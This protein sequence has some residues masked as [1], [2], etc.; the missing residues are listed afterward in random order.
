MISKEL[1][2]LRWPVK[3]AEGCRL[4]ALPENVQA[5]LILY[6]KNDKMTGVALKYPFVDHCQH[7][8]EVQNGPKW[9]QMANISVLSAW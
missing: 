7:C 2:N 4:Q 5:C 6:I 3:L 8:K 9:S 1:A